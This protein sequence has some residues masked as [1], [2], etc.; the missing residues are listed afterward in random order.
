MKFAFMSFSTP[1]MSLTEMLETARRYGY[2]GI[3]PRMD[4]GHAHGIEVGASPEKVAEARRQAADAGIAL[5]CLA[6]SL[7]YADPAKVGEMVQGTHERIDLAAALGI[8]ALRV[9]GGQIPKGVSREQAIAGS[10]DALRSVAGHASE[11]GVTLCL[12]THDDWCTP[13]HVAALMLRVDRPSIRVNWDIMHPVR[14]GNA[15]IDES[16]ETL[17]AWVSHVHVH[18]GTTG[19][20]LEMVPIGQGEIDHRRALDLLMKA[21]YAGHI[22]GEWI[23]W[24]P[25]EVHLPRELATLRQYERELKGA[26]G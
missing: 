23:N 16:F 11:K 7:T 14:R 8:P 6:T 13:A 5:A 21:G 12:E 4:A 10:A 22:S 19:E 24:E 9:F 15:T 2:D 20:K 1:G 17:R 25:W 3:E 26:K 18:D